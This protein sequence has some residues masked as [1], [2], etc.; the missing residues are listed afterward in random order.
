MFRCPLPSTGSARCVPPLRRYYEALRLL[1]ALTTLASVRGVVPGWLAGR[2]RD[3]PGSWVALVCVPSSMTPWSLRTKV[4]GQ[5]AVHGGDAFR[6]E[7]RVG[8][9]H[10]GISG[11]NHTAH[12]PAVYASQPRSPVC[13]LRP[14]KTRSRPGDPTWPDGILTRG[15][16][17]EVLGATPPLQPGL[18]WRTFNSLSWLR[19]SRHDG[20]RRAVTANGL[21]HDYL[22]SK[23]AAPGWKPSYQAPDVVLLCLLDSWI[24]SGRILASNTETRGLPPHVWIQT[25]GRPLPTWRTR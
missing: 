2:R 14:R 19:P 4:D 1:G 7:H 3:L 22:S 23:D 24:S 10:T 25:K 5:S 9:H 12:T 6:V 21:P 15:L 11:L 16:L 13:F 20:A 8:L 18:S 17:S